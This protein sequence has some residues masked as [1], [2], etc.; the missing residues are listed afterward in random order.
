M[1]LRQ[2]VVPF[3]ALLFSSQ[4]ALAQFTQQGPKLVGSGAVASA[5]GGADQGWSVALSAD[6]NTAIV[7]GPVDNSY[8][9][10]AW[11]FS[12]SNGVWA[13]PASKLVGAGGVGNGDQGSSVA[14]SADGNTA[15]V[16]GPADNS[17]AGAAWVFTQSGGIWTQ[18]GTKLVG[19]GAVGTAVQQGYSVAV[20]ADGNTAIVGG[21]NNIGIGA[22]WVYAQ[23]GGVWTQQGS[24]LVG[25]GAVGNSGQGTSVALSADGNTAIVGGGGDNSSVGAAW[26]YIRSG[27]VWTQQGGKLVGTGAVGDSAQGN[28]VAM[29]ADGNTA[30]VGGAGDNSGVGAAWVYVRS[31]GVWNQQGSK[32]VGTG[33]VGIAFQGSASLSADGNTAI[34]GGNADNNDIGAAW[35][36]TRSNGVW[37]QQGSK[38][39]GTGAVGSSVFEGWSVALS[40]DGSTALVGGMDD[41]SSTGA[42]WVFVQS[43]VPSLQ[44]TP[45]TNVV[46]A[47]IPGGPFTPGTF[48]YQLSA[49]T[50]SVNYSISISGAPG[51]LSPSST[52]GNVSSSGTTVTFGVNPNAYMFNPGTYTATITFTNSDTGQGTQ[53][54]TATLTVNAPSVQITPATNIAASGP[55]GGPFSPS[56]F[57][58]A[59]IPSGQSTIDSVGVSISGLPN[60]LIASPNDIAIGPGTAVTFTVDQPAARSLVPGTYGPTTI[61]FTGGAQGPQT[62]TATLTV[63]PPALQVTPATSIAAS[64][65]QGGPFSPL[66]FSYTLSATGGSVNYSITN[67]PN[68]LTPSSTSGTASSSGTTVTFTV[69]A[70]ANSLQANTYV[71]SINFNNSDSGQGNTTLVATL[72]VNARLLQVTP[73]TNVAPVGY[74]GGPFAPS[75]F[76]YQVSASTGSVNY[77]ISGLPNWLTASSTSGNVSSSGTPVTFTVNANANSLAPGTYGPATIIF[78]NSDTGQGTQ[79]RTATLTVNAPVLQV[80]PTAN[81]LA[82]GNQGALPPSSFQYQLSAN[83]SSINYSISGVPTWLTPSSTTGTASTSGTAVTFTVN[84]SANSLAP[85][86]YGPTTITFTSGTGQSTQTRTATLTVN[87]PALLVTPATGDSASGTHGGPFSPSS[88]NYALSSTFGSLKYS[89]TTPSW[90]T[91]SS[92]SGTVTTTAKTITFTVNSSARSLAP[93]TYAGNIGFNN[94]TNNQGNATRAATLVVNPKDYTLAVSATPSADGT[95]SGGGTFAEGTS[96]T[97]TATPKAGHGFVNWIQNAKVVSTAASYTFTMPSANVTLVAH[98][99]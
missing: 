57:G 82:A 61:T 53:T 1:L 54:R 5:N 24:M 96:H 29:S 62:R 28:S 89:I 78:T 85:G 60:W 73:A 95:V 59:L 81:I 47:G 87:P 75:S 38:L 72:A 64:G 8:T 9:G 2:V 39:V 52:S 4:L 19:T 92:G 22:A 69:N 37:T 17:L 14:L 90:L 83:A 97:V 74:P 77:S 44:V 40:A 26:V 12:R 80:T 15:I 66:S 50:G 51:W 76:Q 84:A 98:F 36:F 65:P 20:S 16:G 27:G 23:S 10:A 70:N 49:S 71:N 30:I 33:A 94:T 68:W 79:S 91:A 55:Q 46:S 45:A 99:K 63:N 88:F 21:P 93:S 56:S 25:T 35:V 86:N 3:V 13:Q 6:G 7:G 43:T 41:N 34:V 18:Q 32:L 67:V 31:G 58:Y 42:A 48:Q 11:V